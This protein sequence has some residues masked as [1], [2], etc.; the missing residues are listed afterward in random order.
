[1][2]IFKYTVIDFTNSSFKVDFKLF[3]MGDRFYPHHGAKSITLYQKKKKNGYAPT[4]LH[5][6]NQNKAIG[7]A[8]V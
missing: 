7:I 5:H 8:L 3:E 4:I 1:M 6:L 2:H